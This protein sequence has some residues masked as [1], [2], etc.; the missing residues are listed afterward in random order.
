MP[1][2]ISAWTA[3]SVTPRQDRLECEITEVLRAGGTRSALRQRVEDFTAFAKVRGA[4][5]DE[6]VHTLERIAARVGPEMVHQGDS[7]VGESAPDRLTMM[8][9]WCR[10]R[11]RRVD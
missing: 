1:D 7:Q 6:V 9:R 2:M 5:L 8:V 3:Q 10:G 4:S 11:F